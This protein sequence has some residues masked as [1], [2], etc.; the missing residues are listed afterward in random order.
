MEIRNLIN[1]II[2][3]EGGYVNHPNDRGGPTKFGITLKTLKAFRKDNTLTADDVKKLEKPEAF[4]IYERMYVFNPGFGKIRNEKLREV[5]VDS[6]VMSG[7]ET[8]GKFLQ[9]AVNKILG[10]GE[11][12]IDGAVGPKTIAAVDRC[13]P[14]DLVVAVCVSRIRFLGR[15]ITRDPKQS[16]FAGG[17]MKR[18]TKWLKGGQ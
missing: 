4:R 15:L 17:W 14:E 5:V 3:R 12:V 1:G 8:A 13:D 9:T 2:D 6:G 16:V 7:Q 18:A 11:L 10:A